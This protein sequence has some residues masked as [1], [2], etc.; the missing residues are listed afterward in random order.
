MTATESLLPEIIN[1]FFNKI[2]TFLPFA[3]L[4]HHGSCWRESG[5]VA[6][7]SRSEELDLSKSGPLM[8]S[9][10]DVRADMAGGR[11]RAD[12]VEKVVDDL[13]EQ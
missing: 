1:D 7:G 3:A 5:H 10:P 12:F 8:P 6:D 4:H 9:K 11:L 13:W 2:G